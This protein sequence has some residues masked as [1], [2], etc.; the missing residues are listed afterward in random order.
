MSNTANKTAN[1][2]RAAILGA[3]GYTGA[4]LIRLLSRH[5]SVEIPVLTADRRAGA[6]LGEVF[7]HL[8]GLALP[9][10]VRIEDA[11]FDAVDA[12]FCALPHGTAHEVVAG[13]PERIRVIDLSPDF[14]LF[15]VATYESWYGPHK[16]PDLQASAVYGLSE[17]ARAALPDARIIACPGCYPTSVLLP[18]VP[19]IE[20]GLVD[21]HGII[22]DSKSAVSGAGRA[23]KE[24]NLYG[25]V[26]EGIHA[27]GLGG[28]RHAPEID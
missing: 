11:D 5:P 10:L 21:T 12:V 15:D 7:P 28:H 4:E 18:L 25:E 16:A 9:D 3:S 27:Y 24:A 20:A 22:V 23:A 13:L 6:A 14:R 26:A 19:L 2:V 8:A 17:F 1:K